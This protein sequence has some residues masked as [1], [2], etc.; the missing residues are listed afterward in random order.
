MPDGRSVLIVEARD[1]DRALARACLKALGYRVTEVSN[2]KEALERLAQPNDFAAVLLDC[3]LPGMDGYET[4]TR[5]RQAE[6][7]NG[8]TPVPVVAL[9][10]NPRPDEHEKCRVAGMD[11]ILVKP[12][13]VDDLSAVLDD[14]LKAPPLLDP[15]R[16]DGLQKL[17]ADVYRQTLQEVVQQSSQK[18]E[19]L[20][21]AFVAEDAETLADTAH[22]F[23]GVAAA[24]GAESL[25]RACRE[26][27]T[28]ATAGD[29]TA[30]SGALS[31]V[32]AASRRTVARLV[33]L[34]AQGSS[35]ASPERNA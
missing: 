9:N 3:R 22:A 17:G 14:L 28:H 10:A 15:V 23:Y 26:L 13:G 20:R 8:R 29:L 27:E 31:E 6:R 24:V 25:S 19:I 5:L 2:G 30:C 34:L 11:A 16:L 33:E 1:F 35:D 4:A 12:F 18:V 32:E 7:E 21:E